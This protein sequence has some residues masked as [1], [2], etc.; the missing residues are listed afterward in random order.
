MSKK[1]PE[2]KRRLNNQAARRYRKRKKENQTQS[3]Y[4]K[5]LYQTKK[6]HA[7]TFFSSN[8]SP[9]TKKITQKILM[10]N[11]HYLSD[12]Y[13]L[14]NQLDK[15]IKQIKDIATYYKSHNLSQTQQKF[16]LDK[17]I[18]L[19]VFKNVFGKNKK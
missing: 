18:I 11:P 4:E 10:K 13:Q 8:K 5:N 9:Q 15:K 2:E 19:R 7:R 16:H 3:S 17:E 6:R 14:R 1:S 12:L